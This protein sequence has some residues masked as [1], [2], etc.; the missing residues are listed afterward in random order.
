MSKKASSLR[1]IS[2][3]IFA[4]RSRAF[5]LSSVS[6]SARLAILSASARCFSSCAFST[7]HLLCVSSS[8]FCA[9]AICAV[10]VATLPMF[11]NA[12]F[13]SFAFRFT[14]SQS[15]VN[16]EPISSPACMSTS[17]KPF[18]APFKKPVAFASFV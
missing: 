16:N 2:S 18:K 14:P 11:V 3:S 12:S 4:T 7:C 17:F 5:R 15:R 10:V 13:I 6:S 1:Y 9:S 8:F